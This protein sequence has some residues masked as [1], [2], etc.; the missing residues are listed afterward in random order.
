MMG[1]YRR[2]FRRVLHDVRERRHLEA[3]A[4]FLVTVTLTVVGLVG[5]LPDRV[6]QPVILAALA[7]LI[8]WTTAVRERA[9]GAASLDTV[10]LDREAYGS[11]AELL[12][13]ATEVWMY[14]PTG[15]N[16]LLRHTADIRRWIQ[17]GGT[18][19][20]MVILDPSSPGVEA[21]RAQLD[22]STDLDSALV[23]SLATV[24]RLDAL[25]DFELRLLG[26]NPGF[27]LVVLDPRRVGGRLFVEFHGFQDDSIGDRM[28]LEIRR[29]QSLHWFEYWVGRFEAIWEVAR[30][31]A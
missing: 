31:P 16:V 24:S 21:S 17:R 9:S 23:A 27:S 25:D 6:V 13:G 12:E 7:F 15:V 19:A 26:V 14:A 1:P 4:L 5:D 3:Y 18:S 30:K 29:S 11:F 20:R 10:L 2:G 22:Q 8:F 28:H